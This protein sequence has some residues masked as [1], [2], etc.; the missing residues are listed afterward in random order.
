MAKIQKTQSETNQIWQCLVKSEPVLSE[1]SYY[2]TSFLDVKALGFFPA[3]FK[4]K[5]NPQCSCVHAKKSFRQTTP[6][7]HP[8]IT[9]IISHQ[10]A[11]EHIFRGIY[12]THTLHKEIMCQQSWQL[13]PFRKSIRSATCQD[14]E[15]I[16][17][18]RVGVC[19]NMCASANV[20]HMDE[21][22]F[23]YANELTVRLKY[24]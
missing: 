13:S 1:C 6:W 16:L 4:L 23:V 2:C 17:N 8:D 9:N 11:T 10:H 19:S 5:N 20:C 18:M 14:A 24:L 7:G 22:S 21:I 15:R 3:L 12:E